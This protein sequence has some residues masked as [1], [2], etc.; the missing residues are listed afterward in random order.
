MQV[1]N[2]R[3]RKK[4]RQGWF[5]KDEYEVP[6]LAAQMAKL[7]RAGGL[8][9]IGSHGEM[10]GIG[11][12]WELWMFAS[13]GMTPLEV[14]R[15]ATVNGSKIIGRPPDLGSIEAGKLPDLG[16]MDQNPLHHISNTTNI[17]LRMK[18]RELLERHNP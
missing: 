15:C 2:M 18:N 8:V 11:Y 10:Q 4:V 14:L 9:G 17:Y 13:G 12:H 6:K 16:I 7:V 3:E 1:G 5:R